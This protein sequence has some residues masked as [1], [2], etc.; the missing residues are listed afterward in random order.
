[1]SLPTGSL[2]AERNAI[3]SAL[4][5]DPSLRREH[6]KMVAVLFLPKLNQISFSQKSKVNNLQLMYKQRASSVPN[7]SPFN[8]GFCGGIQSKVPDLN[9]MGPCGS[10]EEWLKKIAECNPCFS[11]VTFSDVQLKEVIIQKLN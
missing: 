11:I 2:C 3:G 6:F 4:A 9:P 10:C 8:I 5:D 1:M 7:V